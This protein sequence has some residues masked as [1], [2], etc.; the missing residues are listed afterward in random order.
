M[1]ISAIINTLNE[2]KNLAYALRS[3][4]PWADEII[5]VDMYS[6]DRTVDIAKSL[7]ATVYLYEGTGFKVPAR[8]FALGKV[9]GDWV[10]VLDADELVTAE[11]SRQLRDIA[12]KGQVDVV[13]VPR[14]NH[15]LGETVSHGGWGPHQDAPLRFFKRDSMFGASDIH[16]E[17]RPHPG[18]RVYR[19]PYDG[20]NGIIH[21]AYLDSFQIFEKL[22]RYTSI[23]AVQTF[24]AGR[25][26]SQILATIEAGKHFVGY[27]LKRKGYKDGW[28]GFYLA[29]SK[30]MY[31][32]A[33]SFKL[34]ELELVG[35]PEKVEQLY[36]A[37]AEELLSAY[38]E[39]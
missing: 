29:I 20:S 17:L 32:L 21:F 24:A 39:C 34:K 19:L 7:G 10:L 25:R 9:S 8:A 36:R 35:P 28:R 18:A 31:R 13:S 16:H 33:V 27:Y 26:S 1:K 23:E 30:V 5:V 4:R 37:H 6:A 2:E 22:N 15:V 11:L 14:V 3:L 38:D 12:E